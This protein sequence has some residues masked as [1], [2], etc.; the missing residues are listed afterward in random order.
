MKAQKN[1][2][3]KS[4][5][6]LIHPL[7]LIPRV[8]SCTI[9][10]TH[11]CRLQHEENSGI[12]SRSSCKC[13]LQTNDQNTSSTSRIP[14]AVSVHAF[15]APPAATHQIQRAT[16]ATTSASTTPPA[17]M[18]LAAHNWTDAV[19]QSLSSS[20][21]DSFHPLNDVAC[22]RTCLRIS[23][24]STRSRAASGSQVTVILLSFRPSWVLFVA[25][26][27]LNVCPLFK[28]TRS[29]HFD[30]VLTWCWAELQA[31]ARRRRGCCA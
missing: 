17:L 5:H 24:G 14:T 27:V 10:P 9:L 6:P 8:S 23:D 2:F 4:S 12:N 1:L 28:S 21:D 15:D 13:P 7:S 16:S 20:L 3:L 29:L 11:S 22:A 26:R 25:D 19:D 30:K 18:L 31:L